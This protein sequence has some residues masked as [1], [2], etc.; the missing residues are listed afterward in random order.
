M[1][2]CGGMTRTRRCCS[3]LVQAICFEAGASARRHDHERWITLDR[4]CLSF[5][6]TQ[7]GGPQHRTD[8]CRQPAE[9]MLVGVHRA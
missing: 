6:Q 9:T 7:P 5:S 3:L 2:E 1:R 8:G 4:T